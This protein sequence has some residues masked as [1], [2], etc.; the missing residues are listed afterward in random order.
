LL[1]KSGPLL[2][3]LASCLPGL[4]LR[5]GLLAQEWTSRHEQGPQPATHRPA[6]QRHWSVPS[7][8]PLAARSVPCP[9]APGPW[10][11]EG[12]CGSFNTPPGLGHSWGEK[13]RKDGVE[14]VIEQDH[15]KE[16]LKKTFQRR[17]GNEVWVSHRWPWIQAKV[18]YPIVHIPSGQCL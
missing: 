18:L 13:G 3:T 11:T 14:G 8:I 15:W 4:Q 17:L 7:Q 12:F 16:P 5:H 2:T 9:H 10:L 1:Q 6:P